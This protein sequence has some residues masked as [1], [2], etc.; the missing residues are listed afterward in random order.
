MKE[1]F[2]KFINDG[3]VADVS[4][5]AVAGKAGKNAEATFQDGIA[6]YEITEAGLMLNAD[7]SG[8]KFWR[9]DELNMERS[10]TD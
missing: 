3:W 2:D 7:I 5:N 10:A 4:A 9:D 6:F 8:T 1:R